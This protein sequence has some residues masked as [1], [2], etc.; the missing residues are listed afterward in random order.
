MDLLWINTFSVFI[1][2]FLLWL[3]VLLFA[4]YYFKNLKFKNKYKLFFSENKNYISYIFLFLSFFVLLFWLFDFKWGEK[5]LENQSEGLD[6]VFVLDVSK[7]MNVL[8]YNDNKY[9]YS[10]LD[11]AKTMISDYVSKNIEHRYWLIVFAWDAISVS[12]LTT[13]QNSFLTFLENVDYRNLATQWSDFVK[14]IDLWVKRFNNDDRSKVMIMLSDWWDTDDKID[15]SSIKSIV[16]DKNIN[17]FVF[18]IWTNNWWNIPIWQDVFWETIYQKYKWEYVESKLNESNLEKIADSL[19]G[20]YFKADNL[21]K[22]SSYID[23]LDKTIIEA[24]KNISEKI[25]WTRY[26]SFIAF[27]FFILYLFSPLLLRRK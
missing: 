14:A 2:L 23:S 15:Y 7:S 19:E 26:L 12:P 18:W 13:D 22:I 24:S 8:D 9:R 10:R 6:V 25:D 4:N 27:I 17:S 3:V 21:D 1:F 11:T 16:K 5:Q 20:K